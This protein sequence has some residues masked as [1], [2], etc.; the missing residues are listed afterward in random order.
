LSFPHQKG[1]SDE[2]NQKS[3]TQKEML[4]GPLKQCL[5]SNITQ[6]NFNSHNR[7]ILWQQNIQKNKQMANPQKL[8][9]N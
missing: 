6:L 1:E 3:E 2:K 9:P 7:K 8:T 4:H 5:K